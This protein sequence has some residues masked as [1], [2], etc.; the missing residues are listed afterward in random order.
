MSGN[1]GGGQPQNMG[2]G[3][4]DNTPESK[5]EA[6][7]LEYTR[8]ATDLA[9]RY[10]EDELGKERPDPRLLERLGGWNDHDLRRF[11]ERWKEMQQQA[12]QSPGTREGRQ[13]DETLRNLGSLAPKAT[14]NINRNNTTQRTTTTESQ[15]YA[16]PAKYT[17]RTNAYTEGINK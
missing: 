10:L 9:I 13:F 16:A 5:P 4:T 15:R 7:N 1:G 17:E 11:V 2:Q 8:Q 14:V 3:T 6:A 12:G